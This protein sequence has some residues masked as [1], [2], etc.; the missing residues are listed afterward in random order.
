[1]TAENAGVMPAM[2]HLSRCSSFDRLIADVYDSDENLHTILVQLGFQQQQ[3][4]L[5]LGKHQEQIFSS[6]LGSVHTTLVGNSKDE[7]LYTILCRRYGLDGRSAETLQSIGQRL[8]SSRERV[9]QLV[10]KA[11]K[12]CRRTFRYRWETEL[13]SVAR[14]LVGLPGHRMPAHQPASRHHAAHVG[15]RRRTRS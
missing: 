5:L 1:M 14:E 2:N 10:A 11:L 12:R 6:F 7:R 4:E 15:R 8:G 9:R 3:I 13:V